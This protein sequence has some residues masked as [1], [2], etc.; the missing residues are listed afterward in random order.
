MERLENEV[1]G[2]DKKMSKIQKIQI[3]TNTIC[4]GRELKIG[5]EVEQHLTIRSDDRYWLSRYGFK[6]YNES[7][8]ISK[9]SGKLYKG[10][11]ERIL[12]LLQERI[13]DCDPFLRVLDCGSWE[14]TV[15]YEDGQQ[16][17]YD[18][19]LK[20]DYGVLDRISKMIR[21]EIDE[22]RLF[23][24]DGCHPIESPVYIF[25]E[26]LPL[27][28]EKTFLWRE[29][30]DLCRDFFWEKRDEKKFFAFVR[31][32]DEITLWREMLD[33]MGG[34][35]PLYFYQAAAYLILAYKDAGHDIDAELEEME[36]Q[37]H[38]FRT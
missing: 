8:L 1:F 29:F 27:L 15:F 18:G 33:N 16:E 38:I 14:L 7:T 5:E 36:G 21:G 4:Y 35:I 34:G 24:F 25:S 2:K 30:Q 10:R 31:D 23:A 9:T 32:P 37:F 3:I 11:A 13:E 6:D 20:S 28:Y 22:D 26:Y 19:S 12:K 17:T